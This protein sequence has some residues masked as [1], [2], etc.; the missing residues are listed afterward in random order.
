MPDKYNIIFTVITF[1][2]LKKKQAIVSYALMLNNDDSVGS[3]N[4]AI[5]IYSSC[6]ARTKK[7][8]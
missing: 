2:S 1:H 8:T 3:F 5:N 4:L 6:H 7:R